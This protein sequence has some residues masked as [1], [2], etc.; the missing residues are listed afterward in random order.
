MCVTNRWNSPRSRWL[1][2]LTGCR[3]RS[4]Q[5]GLSTK[6]GRKRVLSVSDVQG[7]FIL[8]DVRLLHNSQNPEKIGGPVKAV[9]GKNS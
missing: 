3:H 2:T 8:H 9:P 6:E 4:S 1:L 5:L 7:S